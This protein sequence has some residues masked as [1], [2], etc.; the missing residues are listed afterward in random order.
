M[1]HQ[2]NAS[3]IIGS[4]VTYEMLRQDGNTFTI[5]VTFTIYRDF[6]QGGNPGD[7]PL[8]NDIEVAIYR[9]DPSG[10]YFLNDEARDIYKVDVVDKHVP[11]T[12]QSNKCF[13]Q[14]VLPRFQSDKT[15][16]ILRNITL[17][18]I[19]EEYRIAFQ[20]CCRSESLIN[21]VNPR[22]TGLVAEVIITPEA[23]A[24]QNINNSPTFDFDPEVVI[25]NGFEQEILV[26]AND[27]DG[28]ELRYFFEQPQVAGG[29]IG[30]TSINPCPTSD[31][32]QIC[33]TQCDGVFPNP[34]NC[35]PSL[36]GVVDYEAA[37]TFDNPVLA[38]SPFQIDQASGRISG[39]ATSTGVYLIGIRV[40]EWRGG[41]KIGEIHRD[42][43][44]SVTNCNQEAII[45]PPGRSA[46]IDDFILQ[47]DDVNQM[48]IDEWD[49]CGA[50]LVTLENYVNADPDQVTFKWTVFESDG[51]T[52][53]R[54][55]ES[56]WNPAF[57]LPVG[58]YIVRFTLFP[59][60]RCEDFC[61]M[62]LNVTPPLDTDFSLDISSGSQCD[63]AAIPI[64]SPVI[65]PNASYTWDFGDG[66][67]STVLDPGEILYDMPG[68][69]EISLVAERGRCRDT[70]LSGPIDYFPLPSMVRALPSQ[71]EACPV[72]T[73]SFDNLT[74]S[75]PNPYTLEW[76]FDDGKTSS[77]VSPENTFDAPGTYQISL[78]ISSGQS[79]QRTE[80]FPWSIE[81]LP[82]PTAVFSADPEEV[83]NPAQI[84][85]FTNSSMN[86]SSYQWNFGDDTAPSFDENPEH[87]YIEPGVFEVQLLAFST[88]SNCVDTAFFD[89]P[90][91]AAGVPF[92]PNAFN[93]LD[94]QNAE[95]RAMSVFDNFEDFYLAVYDR[96]GKMVFE[97]ANFTEGWNGKINNIGADLP[98]GV[99]VYQYSYE[100]LIGSQRE[101]GASS[102]TVLLVR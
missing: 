94:D 52:E 27:V 18:I 29:S 15:I 78:N 51:I 39:T 90:V 22:E 14:S 25:C 76:D 95:F 44:L 13:D 9:Q 60:L 70:T 79:C 11:I 28:D 43:N 30:E 61:E 42:F 36:F 75:D 49:P 7:I 73:I 98:T 83:T 85:E 88:I 12:L 58:E 45:G 34:R 2:L 66:S 80:V 68:Q 53:Q 67:T 63:E 40:E 5:N 99:Y 46:D 81:I 24:L 87:Q 32:G 72:S 37:Y 102:G 26:T 77:L 69:Y 55:N 35:S 38:D 89:I 59:D 10:N 33:R 96:W 64:L 74:L 50:A 54:R 92:F 23:Q 4:D 17:D 20:R 57:D 65:D 100:V 82:G 84:V 47:C 56:D 101:Q 1:F 97:T 6:Y 71:F 16:Y 86:A 62:Q 41:V 8:P 3:H 93:P 21:I 19:N 91:T 31:T 48:V